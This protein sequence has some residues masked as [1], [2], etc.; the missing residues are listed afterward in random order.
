MLPPKAT[1]VGPVFLPPAVGFDHAQRQ[2]VRDFVWMPPCAWKLDPDLHDAAV[3]TLDFAASGAP[4][5]LPIGLV[6]HG[7]LVAFEIVSLAS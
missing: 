2:D 5:S 3:P 1:L 6:G 4:V 7:V